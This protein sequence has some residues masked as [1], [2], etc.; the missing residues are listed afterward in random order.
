MRDLEIPDVTDASTQ[1]TTDPFTDAHAAHL[2]A[3]TPR[4]RRAEFLVPHH[5]GREMAYFVGNSL[6]LQP[7]GARA[8]VEE[9]LDK[10][11]TEA[12]EGHFTG[13][14]QWMPYHELVREPHEMQLKMLLGTLLVTLLL[15]FGAERISD[16][17]RRRVLDG[18][19]LA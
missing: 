4:S 17:L 11:A 7:R 3:I 16:Y 8:H 15:V 10:W 6:G 13:Q 14:A 1:I 19:K 5:D 18:G 2:D 9:V 12:V